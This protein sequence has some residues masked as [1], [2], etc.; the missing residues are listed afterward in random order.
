MPRHTT[1]LKKLVERAILS[2]FSHGKLSETLF[3]LWI[4]EVNT[5]TT[6]QRGSYA[7]SAQCELTLIE[8]KLAAVRAFKKH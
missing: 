5:T 1:Q 7:T 3:T 6:H 2:E 4:K 8:S